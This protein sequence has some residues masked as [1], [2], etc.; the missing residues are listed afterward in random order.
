MAIASARRLF[1]PP[2]YLGCS[3]KSFWAW[4]WCFFAHSKQIIHCKK[5]NSFISCCCSFQQY[6]CVCMHDTPS[7]SIS[8]LISM[9]REILMYWDPH[10]HLSFWMFI[11]GPT[12]SHQNTIKHCGKQP[13]SMYW[14][15]GEGVD[16]WDISLLLCP[17]V[18]DFACMPSSDP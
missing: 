3:D 18:H 12:Q 17:F 10:K 4:K 8:P 11:D 13:T 15:R 1:H 16:V 5:A 2:K 9:G 7:T 6:M 14:L